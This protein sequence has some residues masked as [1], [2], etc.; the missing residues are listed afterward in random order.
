[1]LTLLW[2]SYKPRRAPK[3]F[4]TQVKEWAGTLQP[5]SLVAVSVRSLL[6]P[7]VVSPG[8]SGLIVLPVMQY[9]NPGSEE[10]MWWEAQVWYVWRADGKQGELHTE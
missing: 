8:C 10:P 5:G 4:A 7:F 6:Q 9:L 3:I 2:C 1:M